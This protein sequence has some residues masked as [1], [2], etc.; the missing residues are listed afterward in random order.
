MRLHVVVQDLD[1]LGDNA[2]PPHLGYHIN[3]ILPY[4]RGGGRKVLAIVE[5]MAKILSTKGTKEH[6]EIPPSCSWWINAF[7]GVISP[8]NS[9]SRTGFR[10]Q[11]SA[12]HLT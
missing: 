2:V 7:K 12:D 3:T 5:E 4:T 9:S 6:E 8:R 10:G 11:E 1:E